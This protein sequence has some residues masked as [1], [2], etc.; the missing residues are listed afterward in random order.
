VYAPGYYKTNYRGL[1]FREF[2]RMYGLPQAFTGYLKSRFMRPAGGTWMPSLWA[3]MEC[4]QEDLSGFFVQAT[5]PH[6]Q[7]FERL[8]FTPCGF[9]KLGKVVDP[10]VRESCGITYLDSTRSH[11]G[12]LLYHRLYSQSERREINQIVI[13]F[14]AS[15]EDGRLSC[16]N[17]KQAFDTPKGN[18]V[19]RLPSYDVAFI[20]TV[21]GPPAAAQRNAPPVSRS[22]IAASMV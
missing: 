8:G 4:K 2:V 22:R 9:Q 21:P 10:A 20:H 15:F 12:Q 3:D 5:K 18:E 7:D 6:R 16:T 14:T 19:I 11:F 13:A 1:R 17:H